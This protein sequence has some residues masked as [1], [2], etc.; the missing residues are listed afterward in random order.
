[1]H[2][3]PPRLPKRHWPLLNWLVRQIFRLLGWRIEGT[4]PNLPKAVIAIAPHTSNWDFVIGMS[5]VLALGLQASWLG[6]K[7][8]FRGS[9]GKLLCFLG[10]IPVDRRHPEGLLEQIVAACRQESQILLGITPEGTRQATTS[11]KNGCCRIAAG[12]Q[13]PLVPVALDF[14]RKQIR[15]FPHWIPDQ[16]MDKNMQR[17]SRHFSAEMAKKPANFLPHSHGP[18]SAKDL[19]METRHPG[20]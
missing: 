17:L 15:I 14:S 11:W 8:L 1:M 20:S 7:G 16:E 10:G 2:E 12:A 18:Q 13:I 19:P 3:I 9:L 6:K 5:A 4:L